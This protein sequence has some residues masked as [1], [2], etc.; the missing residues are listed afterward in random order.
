MEKKTIKI[1]D[2]EIPLT[3]SGFPNK[4]YLTKK[5]KEV[6][7]KLIKEYRRPSDIVYIDPL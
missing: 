7:N 6:I 1:F 2:R 3:K 5:E 4:K